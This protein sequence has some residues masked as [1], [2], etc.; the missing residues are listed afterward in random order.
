MDSS[1]EWV[2]LPPKKAMINLSLASL[3]LQIEVRGRYHGQ[4][5]NRST[6]QSLK[7]NMALSE[8]N[9]KKGGRLE[10]EKTEYKLAYTMINWAWKMKLNVIYYLNILKYFINF[11]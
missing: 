11:P 2:Q 3:D 5:R 8:N 10:P 6:S 7:I 9:Q 1:W 4:N